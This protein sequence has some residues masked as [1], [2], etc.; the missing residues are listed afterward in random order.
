MET[1]KDFLLA[2]WYTISKPWKYHGSSVIRRARDD[3]Y[4]LDISDNQLVRPMLEAL[5]TLMIVAT[6]DR[7]DAERYKEIENQKT[8]A[9]VSAYVSEFWY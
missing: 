8:R 7:R 9:L 5:D 6:R 1:L 3:V 4:R 2:N